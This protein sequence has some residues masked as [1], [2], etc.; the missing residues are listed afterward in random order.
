M[1]PVARVMSLY[2]HHVGT[3]AVRVA[4]CPGR[5]G[6]DGQ[7]HGD[8]FFLHVVN[9]HRD[10]AVDV[11]FKVPGMTAVGGKVFEIA[12]DPDFEIM[13]TLRQRLAP[14]ERVLPASGPWRLPPRL[15]FSHRTGSPPSVIRRM[16]QSFPH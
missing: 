1:M 15:G 5:A 14:A 7:P 16:R 6:R 9:T 11:Q 2:R 13:E 12:A 8:R 4:A 10:R 3:Q